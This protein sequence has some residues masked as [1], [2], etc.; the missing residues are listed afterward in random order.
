VTIGEAMI[1]VEDVL[2]KDKSFK[3]VFKRIGNR[4]E[5]GRKRKYFISVALPPFLPPIFYT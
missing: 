4:L 3:E 1:K 2:Q 5:D